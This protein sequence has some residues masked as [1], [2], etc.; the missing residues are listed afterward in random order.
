MKTIQKCFTTSLLIFFTTFTFSQE[1]VRQNPFEILGRIYDVDITADGFGWAVG[2]AGAI[3]YTETSGDFWEVQETPN[4]EA[5]LRAIAYVEGSNGQKAFAGGNIFYKTE[6]AGQ[7]WEQILIGIP[8]I[9]D[10]D[11]LSTDIAVICGSGGIARTEDGGE[12]W[13]ELGDFSQVFNSMYWTD[14]QTGYAVSTEEVFKTTDGGNNWES[15]FSQSGSFFSTITFLDNNTGYLQGSTHIYKTTNAGLDW[16]AINNE[17]FTFS[18]ND[19]H[20]VNENEMWMSH[21]NGAFPGSK[22]TDGG[23]TWTNIPND[24]L[25]GRSYGVFGNDQ[26][27]WITGELSRIGFTSDGGASFIDQIPGNKNILLKASFHDEQFGLVAGNEGALLRTQNGGMIWEDLSLDDNS[28]IFDVFVLDNNYCWAASF[29]GILRS[30]DGGDNWAFVE[31]GMTSRVI[32]AFSANEVISVLQSGEIRRSTDGGDSWTITHDP[33]FDYTP[34]DIMFINNQTGWISGTNGALFKTT[35]GGLSWV[36]IESPTTG[37]LG[38]IDFLTE[39]TGFLVPSTFGDTLWK[40]TDGGDSWTPLTTGSST[41]FRSVVFQDENTGWIVGGSS[42]NGR[43][44]HTTDGGQNWELAFHDVVIY[45]DIAKQG[46]DNEILWA[47]GFGGSILKYAPCSGV[48]ELTMLSGAENPCVGDTIDYEVSG[49]DV[50]SYDWMLPNG[51]NIFGNSNTALV[52][53]VVGSE[54]GQISIQGSNTCENSNILSIDVEPV[55]RPEQPLISFDG[56]TLS[57]NAIT[58]NY[59]W[60][61]NGNPISTASSFA[62]FESGQYSLIVS[63]GDCESPLSEILEVIISSTNQADISPIRLYPNPGNGIFHL[64]NILSSGEEIIITVNDLRGKAVD[65]ITLENT[66]LDISHLNPGLYILK[67]QLSNQQY[68]GKVVIK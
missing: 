2:S 25:P 29:D 14:L 47:V 13:T 48:P 11:V 21:N 36:Q 51:W 33:G 49:T 6:N 12:T 45:M 34:V 10:I 44:F 61:L 38:G 42:G 9:L 55:S 20:L 30:E 27:V 28:T 60:F 31:E 16:T 64:E 52:Q 15:I 46:P 35:D 40:T 4:D 24:D 8:T 26:G 39:E 23:L 59:Q 3:L 66:Y 37:N 56:Q 62:P 7:T 54:P 68:I 65:Q 19:F 17:A 67:F 50:A 22:S 5:P 57:S 41:F 43:I 53:I 18:P 58:E 1:W 32:Y 63:N